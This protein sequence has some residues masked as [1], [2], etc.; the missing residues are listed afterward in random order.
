MFMTVIR[1]RLVIASDPAIIQDLRARSRESWFHGAT[2]AE[3]REPGLWLSVDVKHMPDDLATI[4]DAIAKVVGDNSD[5]AV[6]SPTASVPKP[7]LPK[8]LL[9][10]HKPAASEMVQGFVQML[11]MREQM[12][13]AAE[14]GESLAPAGGK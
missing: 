7:D 12:K 3:M 9:Y 6:E 8:A 1:R 2:A 4:L 10:V 11:G 5:D 13:S 14:L